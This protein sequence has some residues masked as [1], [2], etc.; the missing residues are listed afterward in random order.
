M[1]DKQPKTYNEI[2]ILKKCYTLINYYSNITEN[3]F[4]EIYEFL[5]ESP[6]N[7]I[8]AN[9]TVLSLVDGNKKIIKT[10]VVFSRNT[11]FDRININ[12]KGFSVTPYFDSNSSSWSGSSGNNNNNNNNNNS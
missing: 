8:V 2:V 9:R 3:M 10:Y 1:I 5:R 6:D 12:N 4:N 7:T 11:S